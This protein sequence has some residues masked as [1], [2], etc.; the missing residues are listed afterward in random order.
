M[1][2]VEVAETG[3]NYHP[4]TFAV[5]AAVRRLEQRVAP[6]VG[7]GQR[8]RSRPTAAPKSAAAAAQR[9][10]SCTAPAMWVR[11]SS[12]LQ[13]PP[14]TKRITG[15]MSGTDPIGSPSAEVGGSCLASTQGRQVELSCTLRTRAPPRCLRSREFLTESFED[16]QG[17]SGMHFAGE[18]V[19][20][21]RPFART[22][23]LPRCCRCEAVP[24]KFFLAIWRGL[25]GTIPRRPLRQRSFLG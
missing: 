18:K 1:V 23:I 10:A 5:S 2:R 25:A 20:G 12:G 14:S 13:R 21:R 4:L 11:P 9:A 7:V 16:G 22:R 17:T 3:S 6:V 24:S 19:D 15:L 8:A